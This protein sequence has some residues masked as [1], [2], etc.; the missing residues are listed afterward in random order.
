[1][2]EDKYLKARLLI[3]TLYRGEEHGLEVEVIGELLSTPNLDSM[4]VDEFKD[5]CILALMEWVK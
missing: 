3:D 1:M 4:T 2:I 5:R